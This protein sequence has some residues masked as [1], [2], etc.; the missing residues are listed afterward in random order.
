MIQS[1]ED[2]M[3]GVTQKGGKGSLSPRDQSFQI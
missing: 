3:A 1:Y 2:W